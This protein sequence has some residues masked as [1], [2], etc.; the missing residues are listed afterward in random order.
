MCAV[1]HLE[2][3][4]LARAVEAAPSG[5]GE[6]DLVHAGAHPQPVQH[7]E[8]VSGQADG[9]ATE[10]GREVGLENGHLDAAAGQPQ[11]CRQAHGAPADDDHRQRGSSGRRW[12]V[13]RLSR[14]G[15]GI[16]LAHRRLVLRNR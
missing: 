12:V 14:P 1:R 7:F 5:P 13:A 9:A 2:G 15:V 8:T 4:H 16:D 10:G 6:G 3:Q 11:S